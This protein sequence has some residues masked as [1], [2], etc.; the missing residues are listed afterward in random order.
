MY[1]TVIT[2]KTIRCYLIKVEYKSKWN[3]EI[4]LSV[5]WEWKEKEQ[6]EGKE[7]LLTNN[8]QTIS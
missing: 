4:C 5:S 3:P 2:E 8:K 6:D 1:I 7:R